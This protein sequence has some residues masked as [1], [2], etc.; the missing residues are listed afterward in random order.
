MVWMV[1]FVVFGVA[2][3]HIMRLAQVQRRDMWWVGATNYVAATV[4]SLAWWAAEARA[5]LG[6][7][8][9]L[10][11]LVAGL[12]LGAA[13][14]ILDASIRLVGVGISNTVGRLSIAVPVAASVLVWG[15]SLSPLRAAGFVLAML[16]SVLLA[17]V[18]AVRTPAR[19]RTRALVLAA[20][21]SVVGVVG[22]CMKALAQ[23]EVPGG[24]TVFLFFMFAT[25]AVVLL[26]YAI[27]R[28]TR[29]SP[30][31][32]AH[33]LALGGVNIIT[34]FA[35]IEALLIIDAT[36]VFP[37]TSV[38]IILLSAGAGALFWG[39]RFRRAGIVGLSVASA[40]MVLLNI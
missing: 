31:D 35:I 39:E 21:F 23:M 17:Q 7:G 2:F 19:G 26:A 8:P 27:S 10:L 1:L 40:A 9:A 12:A 18:K 37:T 5:P 34:Q 3:G 38:G 4:L 14:F 28:R 16:A 30:G 29:P 15:E 24:G 13:Y 22:L 6:S 33:G 32:V 36:V 25:A 20:F 11:G